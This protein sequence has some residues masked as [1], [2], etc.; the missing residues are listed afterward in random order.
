MT[1]NFTGMWSMAPETLLQAD[2]RTLGLEPGSKPSEVR[3]A[4]RTLVKKWHPDRYHS[5]PYET[6]ALAEKKFREI[7]EAYRRISKTRQNTAFFSSSPTRTAKTRPG[8][9]ASGG[10]SKI[11]FRLSFGTKT[12][13]TVLVLIAAVLL[14]L[15]YT[16]FLPDTGLDTEIDPPIAQ[17]ATTDTGQDN[18]QSS[19][20]SPQSSADLSGSDLSASTPL[21]LPDLLQSPLTPHNAFFSL[22]ST[23]TEVIDVQGAPSRVLGQIWTYGLSEVQFKNGRVCKFNNFDGSLRIRM[24]PKVSESPGTPDHITLGSSQEEVLLV[25]GTPTRLDGNSWFYGFAELDFKDGRV[26]EYDNYFG[27]LK[28]RLLPS[29]ATDHKPSADYFTIGSTPDDVLAVQG[30]PTSVHG[31]RWSFN[32]AVVVFRDGKVHYVT[33]PNGTTLHFTEP[34]QTGAAKGQ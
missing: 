15:Q 18:A 5:K 2:F 31:N 13:L 10:R 26:A 11:A 20:P 32:F 9:T 21:P 23:T 16:S 30:T 25:H 3:R 29:I 14:L 8:A 28:I 7:D 17:N 34:E 4:Y 33:D 12:I 6:R 19:A 22:G 1:K 27:N 24:Q